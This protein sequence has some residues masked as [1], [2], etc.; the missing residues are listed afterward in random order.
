MNNF[1]DYKYQKFTKRDKIINLIAAKFYDCEFSEDF[2]FDSVGLNRN[3][4]LEFYNCKFDK[5]N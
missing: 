4:A 2:S 1:T 5:V 3:R